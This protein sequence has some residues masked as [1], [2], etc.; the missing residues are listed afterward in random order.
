MTH[1]HS[2]NYYGNNHG[3]SNHSNLHA[4][5]RNNFF[6]PVDDVCRLGIIGACVSAC[7]ISPK[8]AQVC[9]TAI[10]AIIVIACLATLAMSVTAEALLSVLLIG[11]VI[12]GVACLCKV[13]NCCEP[14]NT[15]QPQS[16]TY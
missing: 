13:N 16:N 4:H 3:H 14:E 9:L 15:A 1:N 5:R 7:C 12:Y 2:E 10:V 11:A 6:C 8:F